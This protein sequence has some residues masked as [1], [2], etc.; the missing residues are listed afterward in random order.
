MKEVYAFIPEPGNKKATIAVSS[1]ARAMRETN[2]VA[3]L[4]CVWRQGQGNVTIGVLTPNISSMD[5][6]VIH[7]A[8]C[9]CFFVYMRY[10]A[11]KYKPLLTH[12]V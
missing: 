2:K 9:T 7:Q 10:L 6:M 4:R 3:I 5:T 1:I 12:L 8:L 11:S